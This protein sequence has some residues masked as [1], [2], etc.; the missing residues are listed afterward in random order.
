MASLP[1][2]RWPAGAHAEVTD[3]QK[4]VVMARVIVLFLVAII[5]ASML[6][7]VSDSRDSADWKPTHQGVREARW[8]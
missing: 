3:K 4:V 7:L 6:G 2:S 8:H 1:L 5:L